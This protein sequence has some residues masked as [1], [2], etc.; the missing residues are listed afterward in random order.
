MPVPDWLVLDRQGRKFCIQ[1]WQ[2]LKEILR[3]HQLLR[4]LLELPQAVGQMLLGVGA[5][6]LVVI[7][8]VL[9]FVFLTAAPVIGAGILG[10][11]STARRFREGILDSVMPGTSRASVNSQQCSY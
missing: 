9:E 11:H 4:N 8:A 5:L 2:D 6:V 10:Y 3:P 7:M 1:G